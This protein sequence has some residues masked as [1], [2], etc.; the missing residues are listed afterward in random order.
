MPFNFSWLVPGHLAGMGKPGSG[1]EYTPQML[2]H[3]QRLLTWLNTSRTLRAPREDIPERLGLNVRDPRMSEQRLL[4]TYRKFR[5][6]WRILSSVREGFGEGGEP[7]DHFVRNE[8]AALDDLEWVK[9]QGV[10]DLVTLT[11]RPADPEHLEATGVEALHIPVEDQR[12]PALEQLAQFVEHVDMMLAN[13]RPVAV[14]CLAG[15]GRTGTFLA[16]YLVHCG[17]GAEDAIKE[18]RLRRPASIENEEQEQAVH[19]FERMRDSR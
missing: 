15:I 9:A 6:V 2:P 16:S 8:Q 19:Q 13:N 1:L 12:A 18:V 14:H 5:D 17:A 11:E 10:R 3:E 7:V 4:E